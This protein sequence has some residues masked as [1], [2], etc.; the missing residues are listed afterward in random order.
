MN[1]A[2]YTFNKNYFLFNTEMVNTLDLN[3]ITDDSVVVFPNN[4]YKG[5]PVK[6]PHTK[7][8]PIDTN[9]VY[10]LTMGKRVK[11]PLHTSKFG[12]LPPGMEF[13]NECPFGYCYGPQSGRNYNLPPGCHK[14]R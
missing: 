6:E 7:N 11:H 3:K 9:T 8:D 4:I 2:T 5:E 14:P 12:R 10:W 13:G 1:F